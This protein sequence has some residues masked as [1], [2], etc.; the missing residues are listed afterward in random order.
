MNPGKVQLPQLD[1]LNLHDRELT[2]AMDNSYNMVGSNLDLLT[3]EKIR[4][5]EYI[6]FSKLLPRDKL[7]SAAEEGCMDL[8]HKGGQT[9]F[10]PA[11][12]R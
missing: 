12:E 3:K 9:Y 5:G 11:A 6:D 10:I 2:S 4:K 8:V 1:I 7:S